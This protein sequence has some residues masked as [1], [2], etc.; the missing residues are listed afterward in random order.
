MDSRDSN[1][2]R[3]PQNGSSRPNASNRWNNTS[4]Y[5]GNTSGHQNNAFNT[6][7]RAQPYKTKN[8]SYA[9]YH[10]YFE[11]YDLQESSKERKREG[12]KNEVNVIQ[13]T[14]GILEFS[15]PSGTA[16]NAWDE[17][18]GY[19]SFRLETVYPGLLIGLGNSHN[20]ALEGA[21]KCGFS[22]DYTT[23]LPYLP[24]SSLKGVLRSYFPGSE[25][26]E[27][28]AEGKAGFIQSLLPETK[29]EMEELLELEQRIFENGMVFLGAYPD[30]RKNAKLMAMDY[31]TKHEELKN[32]VPVALIKVRP[33]VPFRFCFALWDI[34][35]SSGK[36][37]P[38]EDLLK[39]FRGIILTMGVG[40]KTNTGY[41]RFQEPA[42]RTTSRK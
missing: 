9:F 21:V 2:S 11:G 28:I 14:Q 32:P 1:Q 22:F 42:E 24:G 31:I 34:T 5:R 12:S 15:F 13:K 35:L 16:L 41:G 27:A 8:M 40:A 18:D 20:L 23:G 38:K 6:G 17:M 10:E 30:I 36:N 19:Q 37:I 26:K 25:K 7:N 3:K 29:L 39:L 4:G 33:G